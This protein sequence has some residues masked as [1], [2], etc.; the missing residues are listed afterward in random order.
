M[1]T[2][3]SLEEVVGISFA[4][5][6]QRLIGFLSLLHTRFCVSFIFPVCF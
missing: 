4:N 3:G 2:T 1:N 5:S 6:W